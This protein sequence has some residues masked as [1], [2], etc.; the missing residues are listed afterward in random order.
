MLGNR[1][2]ELHDRSIAA[3]NDWFA[4]MVGAGL[5]FHPDDDPETIVDQDGK[6]AFTGSE[7]K[8]LR[9]IIHELFEVHGEI[10]YECGLAHYRTGL[11][12]NELVH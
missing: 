7:C 12:I 6:P 10:V 3:M 8:V 9:V 1:I 11:G 2:P 4:A 5:A